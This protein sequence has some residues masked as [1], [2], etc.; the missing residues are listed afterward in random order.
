MADLFSLH[1]YPALFQEIDGL[2]ISGGMK[3]KRVFTLKHRPPI[4]GETEF[5]IV[6][7]IP[8]S[9]DVNSDVLHVTHLV[10]LDALIVN[11]IP[12]VQIHPSTIAFGTKSILNENAND[13]FLADVEKSGRKSMLDR[14][15]IAISKNPTP[16]VMPTKRIIPAIP[17]KAVLK[18]QED[19]NDRSLST[20]THGKQLSTDTIDDDSRT[21][22]SH[23]LETL[24]RHCAKSSADTQIKINESPQAVAVQKI[25]RSSSAASKISDSFSFEN[26][27]NPQIKSGQGLI[28]AHCIASGPESN[29]PL[30]VLEPAPSE[31]EQINATAENKAMELGGLDI[32]DK[33]MNL[34]SLDR[35]EDIKTRMEAIDFLAKLGVDYNIDP[36][37]PERNQATF[38][39]EDSIEEPDIS[40]SQMATEHKIDFSARTSTPE[41]A[42]RMNSQH[43]LIDTEDGLPDPTTEI[44]TIEPKDVISPASAQYVPL[45]PAKMMSSIPKPSSARKAASKASAAIPKMDLHLGA[46]ESGVKGINID[47]DMNGWT[48]NGSGTYQEYVPEEERAHEYLERESDLEPLVIY[49]AQLEQQTI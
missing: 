33:L 31:V 37:S 46:L 23:F 14:K 2:V 26:L 30:L 10:R 4:D 29:E 27:N 49:N 43:T 28:H 40:Y 20:D 42:Y 11:V 6:E 12:K 1:F 36:T 21:E 25:S 18:L 8:R 15:L 39:M 22:A 19:I 41:L 24:G 35:E 7:N 16:T 34:E 38:D 47:F 17:L 48:A 3:L 45:Y 9:I 32:N 5:H 13:D 44:S